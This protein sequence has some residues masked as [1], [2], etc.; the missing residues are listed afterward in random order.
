MNTWD[1]LIQLIKHFPG[2]IFYNAIFAE[3]S[4]WRAS[5]HEKTYEQRNQSNKG[6]YLV[7]VPQR[8]F[9]RPPR[10][11]GGVSHRSA[12]SVLLRTGTRDHLRDHTEEAQY[13]F[14]P[15][16]NKSA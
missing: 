6:A 14:R 15:A 4:Y 7:R 10:H 3:I 11:L 8:D 5:V 13:Y 16:Q 12:R 1:T 9:D 2:Q